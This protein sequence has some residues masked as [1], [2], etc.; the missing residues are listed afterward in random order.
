MLPVLLW[1]VLA[2]QCTS[3]Q[4]SEFPAALK[5]EKHGDLVRIKGSRV[6]LRVPAG[7]EEMQGLPRL[8]K[9]NSQYIMAFEVSGTS[10]TEKRPS[11][12]KEKMEEQG[13]KVDVY[14]PTRLNELEAVYFEGPSKK[15][16]ETK[17]GIFFGNDS[18]YIMLVGVCESADDAGKQELNA[19]MR[20]VYY[21]P[22]FPLDPLELSDYEFDPTIL[23][24]KFA[25]SI[26]GIMLFTP[27]GTTSDDP[28]ATYLG[29]QSM[30]GM[31]TGEA[32]TYAD[33]MVARF[34]RKGVT[35]TD[36]TPT[37]TTINGYNAIVIASGTSFG[38]AHGIFYQ[39]V[40]TDG[41]STAVMMAQAYDQQDGWL[42]KFQRTAA[43]I[44]LK[45]SQ[46]SR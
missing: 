3:A 46:P 43:S 44:V 5:T 22:T 31:S 9:N 16:G 1:C 12:S 42:P 39:A 17:L 29:I 36:P 24:F 15:P 10:F 20:T 34:R 37:S 23:G 40:L 8:H 7:Y 26:S 32:R 19:M 21:D 35:F 25:M 14:L 2:F 18:T 4:E 28:T 13:A 30:P 11:L 27:D 33:D 45:K 38:D 41:N 6:F